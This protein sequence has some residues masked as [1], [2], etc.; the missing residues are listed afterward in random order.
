MTATLVRVTA[1]DAFEKA[2]E[3]VGP[4]GYW[5]LAVKSL[6]EQQQIYPGL[7]SYR[8]PVYASFWRWVAEQAHREFV[9]QQDVYKFSR[10]A[11]VIG[12]GYPSHPSCPEPPYVRT[13]IAS[14]GTSV[15][16]SVKASK[17]VELLLDKTRPLPPL[18]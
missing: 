10:S 16:L 14:N 11:L 4:S 5:W 15:F 17:T 3:A 12:C 13:V 8:P 18:D 1:S 7:L 2:K 9:A 6:T